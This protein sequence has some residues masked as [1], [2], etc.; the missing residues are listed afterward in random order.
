MKKPYL[1]KISKIGK[2][3]VWWVNGMYIR[4]NVNREFTNFS[5]HF[6]FKFIPKY[7]FWIDKEYDNG[8]DR[9]FIDHLLVEWKLMSKGIKYIPALD[10]ACEK[11]LQERKKSSLFKKV[12]NKFKKNPKKVPK[13][14]YIKLLKEYSK[15]SIKV[16]L[17]NGEL[18]RDLYYINFTEGGHEYVYNFVPKKEVWIDDDLS[19]QE[20]KFV[21]LHEVHER[22]LMSK[23]YE[24]H[25]A[26]ASSSAIEYEARHNPAKTKKLLD[27]EYAKNKN[28]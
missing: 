26:H 19:P 7:E 5:H 9:F 13:E 4:N 27:S 11:E 28:V 25:K 18:V 2:F 3:S 20:R 15:D 22:F 8:E 14:V 1:K 6:H 21:I 10:K 23:G 24:Y 12:G 17:V 16:F